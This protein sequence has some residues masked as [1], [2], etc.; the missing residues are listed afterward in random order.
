MNHNPGENI[1]KAKVVYLFGN[2]G[3]YDYAALEVDGV[4]LRL[5]YADYMFM[6]TEDYRNEEWGWKG[7]KV[8]EFLATIAEA[9]NNGQPS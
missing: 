3:D 1:V 4:H 9:I 7:P 8:P 5:S 6:N 2:S